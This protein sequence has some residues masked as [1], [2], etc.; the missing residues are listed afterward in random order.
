MKKL[1]IIALFVVLGVQAQEE[2]VQKAKETTKKVE[3][4]KSPWKKGGNISLLFNQSNFD[5][6]LAGGENNI[7]GNLG[8]NYDFNYAKKGWT[9]DNKIIASYGLTKIEGQKTKKTDDRFE[10]NSLAGRKAGGN[11]YYSAFVNFRTQM[12]ATYEGGAIKSHFMSPAYLQFGPGM[13]WK[14]SDNLKVNIA[15]ATGKF[16]FVSDYFTNPNRLAKDATYFGVEQGKTTRYE[17]GAA[18]NVYYK[19]S[20]MKNVTMENILNLYSNYMNNPQNIDV[21][22]TM[23]LVMA[24]NKYLSTNLSFQALYDH[25]AIQKLQRRQV[26]GIGVNY[27]F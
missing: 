26:L 25:D 20:L 24:I 21:D 8:L 4:L 14:K 2:Q 22:Y 16:T 3:E 27:G 11:W 10:L 19:L 12:S 9:W 23:N 6:W 13:L 1:V 18:I 5:N 7:A 15:P 17:L